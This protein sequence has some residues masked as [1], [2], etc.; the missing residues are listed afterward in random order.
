MHQDFLESAE[1]YQHR[2]HNFSSRVIIPTAGLFLFVLL[3]GLFATKEITLSASASLEPNRVIANIQSTSNNTITTNHLA[4][5][6]V[7]KKGEL[8]VQ[9]Q[10]PVSRRRKP[11]TP[12]SWTC[13][14]TKKS[15]W[16]SYKLVYK[17]GVTNSLLPITLATS[18]VFKIISTKL[19]AYG[20]IRTNK[21]PASLPKMPAPA[22]PKLRLATS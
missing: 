6:K 14:K 16:S 15:S 5:N 20:A 13:S 9:Y 2:Y 12:V 4:E 3:F 17:L 18:K 8:L 11:T 1:F 22:T 21:T 10:I 19:L 7:V